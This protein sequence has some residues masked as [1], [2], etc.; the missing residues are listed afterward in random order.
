[1]V[2]IRDSISKKVDEEG[3][4]DKINTIIKIYEEEPEEEEDENGEPVIAISN[5]SLR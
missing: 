1:M 5:S 2:S 3:F 4:T